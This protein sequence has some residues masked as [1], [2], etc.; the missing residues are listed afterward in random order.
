MTEAMTRPTIKPLMSCPD[1]RTEI[2]AIE[3]KSEQYDDYTFRCDSC[4]RLEVR[5]LRT[6]FSEA[7]ATAA[8]HA[9]SFQTG[10]VRN[11]GS[12]IIWCPQGRVQ[13]ALTMHAGGRFDLMSDTFSAKV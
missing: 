1:C 11:S 8:S 9:A 5:N 6:A 4:R 12:S 10:I 13:Q 2:F 3:P 7:I